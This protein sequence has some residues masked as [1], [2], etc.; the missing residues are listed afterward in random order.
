[1]EVHTHTHTARKKWTHYLWEF[2]MLFLAVFCG[3]LAE[4]QREHFVEHQREKKYAETLLEDLVND[5]LE[6]NSDIPFWQNMINLVDTVRKEIEKKTSERNSLL[7][8]R[9]AALLLSNDNFTYH[10]RTIMQLKNAGNFRLI[11]N[12]NVADSIIE[13]DARIVSNLKD[14]EERYTLIYFQNREVL[15]E[16]LFNTKFYSLRGDPE[17]LAEAAN[18]EPEIIEVIKGKEDLLIQYYNALF[19]LGFQTTVRVRIQKN[20][21]SRAANI[22]AAIKK[23]YDLK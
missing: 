2:L 17:K 9:C 8:Y 3:F 21:L 1:M 10:D 11:R 22:I 7:L 20:L 14:L 6:F 19:A 23:E 13:Y 4:N 12:K 15:Q 16:Q 5:T 18:R